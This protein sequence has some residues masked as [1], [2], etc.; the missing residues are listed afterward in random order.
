[1]RA[2]ACGHLDGDVADRLKDDLIDHL[3]LRPAT[4]VDGP[5]GFAADLLAV[6]FEQGRAGRSGANSTYS[7]ALAGASAD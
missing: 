5:R 2:I 7:P 6:R 1:M 4:R 3:V